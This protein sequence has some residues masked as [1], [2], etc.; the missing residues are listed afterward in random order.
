MSRRK[1][2]RWILGSALLVGAHAAHA[3][4]LG[5]SEGEGPGRPQAAGTRATF[6]CL[7]SD[8]KTGTVYGTDVYTAESAVC[9]AAIHAGVLKPFQAGAVTIVFGSG[10]RS[11][12]RSTSSFL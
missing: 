2:L 3:Q 10:A 7:A 12:R 6:V 1:W 8:G 4:M 5:L 11:H 9:A